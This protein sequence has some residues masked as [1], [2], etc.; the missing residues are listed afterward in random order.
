MNAQP[1]P[2]S[3]DLIADI[4]AEDMGRSMPHDDIGWYRDL[5]RR[6]G[7]PTLE[8]GCGTGRILLP[9]LRD[10][11][12]AV[13]IDLSMPMLRR[14]RR[15]AAALG[16]TAR[17]ARMS[18]QRL[19]LRGPFSTVLAPYSL[20]TYLTTPGELRGFLDSA[21]GLLAP[22]GVLVL[23]GFVPRPVRHHEEFRPDYRRPYAHGLLAR[24]KRITVLDDGCHRIERRYRLHDDRG[25]LREEF[26][27]RDRIRP[28]R[29]PELLAHAEAAGLT[30]LSAGYDYGATTDPAGAQ[31]Y[32]LTLHRG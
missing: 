10:G 6:R 21:R 24:D 29:E 25:R 22:D 23:D 16:L 27:T 11:A 1:H 26:T 17:V 5:C 20:V 30:A 3:Y 9:L 18:L 31:F 15:D 32:T 19:A 14:L 13:G 28:R 8:L 4:Y 7:G 2:W 12:D